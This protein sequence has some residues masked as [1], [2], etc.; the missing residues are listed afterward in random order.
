MLSLL[1]SLANDEPGSLKAKVVALYGLLIGVQRGGVVLGVRGVSP[2]S[3]AAGNGIS[4][5]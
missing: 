5:L 2:V 1:R 4:G 3:G